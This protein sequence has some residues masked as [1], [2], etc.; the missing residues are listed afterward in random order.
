[1]NSK[2]EEEGEEAAKE[3]AQLRHKRSSPTAFPKKSS[4]TKHPPTH[5][6]HTE[7]RGDG[8]TSE[9]RSF[10]SQGRL[11]TALLTEDKDI[12]GY[13]QQG[14][15]TPWLHPLSL[16]V[17]SESAGSVSQLKHTFLTLSSPLAA[18]A[19]SEQRHRIRGVTS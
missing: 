14:R 4:P 2:K 1:V 12:S 3:R 11:H 7:S 19:E 8:R 18:S 9:L 10:A 15:Y 13:Q 6:P 16:M 5:T 17:I